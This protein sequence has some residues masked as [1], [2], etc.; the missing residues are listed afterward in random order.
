MR[1]ELKILTEH[2]YFTQDMTAYLV[3]ITVYKRGNW[4]KMTL[5]RV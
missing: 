5:S 3:N 4:G 2:I 1:R